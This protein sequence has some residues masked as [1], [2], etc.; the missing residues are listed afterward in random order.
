MKDIYFLKLKKMT[1]YQNGKIYKITGGGL[2]YYGSTTTTLAKRM[3]RH[4]GSMCSSIQI[5]DLPDCKSEIIEY[6]PCNSKAEL[7]RREG[8]YQVNNDCI[9][10]RVAGR[11]TAEF[12]NDNKEQIKEKSREYYRDNSEQSLKQ[13]KEYGKANR[14]KLR[15]KSRL[16][17]ETHKEEISKKKKEYGKANREYKS[18]YEKWCR[19]PLGILARSYF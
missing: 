7:E 17:G 8:W 11:T 1:N 2:T 19:G 16:Y 13:K 6:Y 12:Y 4:R 15:E 3:G 10:S 9:N 14:E 5:I 18:Q